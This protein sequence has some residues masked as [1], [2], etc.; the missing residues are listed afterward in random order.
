MSSESDLM[1]S[2]EVADLLGLAH[3]N[4]VSG[5]QRR[6]PDMPMPE[7]D[8]GPGRPKLWRREAVMRWAMRAGKIRLDR[9]P[10]RDPFYTAI[11]DGLDGDL[12]P[13]RFE[14]CV[15]D[16]LQPEIPV[17]PVTG[18]DDLG[19]DGAVFDGE[20]PAFPLIA[21][22]AEDAIGNL[23]KNLTRYRATGGEGQRAVFATSRALTSRK[24]RNLETRAESLG[25][26][27]VQ[28]VDRVGVA[29]RLYRHPR[30]CKELLGITGE[31]PPL[32]RIP[33]SPRPQRTTRLIGREHELRIL[34]DSPDDQVL[35]GPPGSGKSALLSQLVDSAGALFLTA[36]PQSAVAD[37]VR[38]QRPS[39]V[40]VDDAHVNLNM[41]DSLIHLRADLGVPFRIVA[42]SWPQDA[43]LV[44]KR[45]GPTPEK[46]L[47]LDRLTKD[48]IV[49]VV[50]EAG[51][52]GPVDLVRE[53]VNQSEGLPGLAVTLSDICL[54]T[55]TREVV[56]GNAISRDIRSTIEPRLGPRATHLLA[57]LAL[58]GD[59]GM[60]L[61][62]VSAGLDLPIVD[63][64]SAAVD[65]AAA[66][67]LHEVQENRLSVRP[68]A[69]RHALV[70]DIFFSPG[71]RLPVE[72]FVGAASANDF[73][74]TLVQVAGLGGQVPMPLMVEA[75]TEAESPLAWALW[76]RNGSHEAELAARDRP[77][78]VVQYPDPFLYWVPDLAFRIL[79]DRAEGDSRELGPNPDHPLRKL[80][81]WVGDG[82]V[83]TQPESLIRRQNMTAA[84]IEWDVEHPS[85][86]VTGR[87]LALAIHPGFESHTTDP[88]MG[89]TVTMSWGL[90]PPVTLDGIRDMW[91][92][93][94][95]PFVEAISNPTRVLRPLIDEVANWVY[96][97][98]IART[99]PPANVVD[100][101]H[102]TAD[103]MLGDLRRL[104]EGH[105]GLETKIR[106]LAE[107][108]G[109]PVGDFD[110][111]YAI[112]Y[113]D[114]DLQNWERA[115][116]D[117]L[118][119]VHQLADMWVESGPQATVE[120]LASYERMAQEVE[121]RWPRF[122]P[123]LAARLASSIDDPFDWLHLML[124]ENLESDIVSPFM[125]NLLAKDPMEGWTVVAS[126]LN[127][128]RYEW[129]AAVTIL[130]A[131]ECPANLVDDAMARLSPMSRNLFWLAHQ[132]GIQ[133]NALKL[134]LAHP[135]DDVASAVALGLWVGS[136]SAP[137]DPELQ[138][139]WTDAVVRAP[140]Q[141]GD[142]GH[143]LG[144][145]LAADKTLAKEWLRRRLAQRPPPTLIGPTPVID[146]I[147][148]LDVAD[149]RELVTE[150]VVEF[151]SGFI[152]NQ[153]VGDST[154]V[155][156]ALL[157]QVDLKP[158]HLAPLWGRPSGTWASLALLALDYGYSEEEL[159]DAA[160]GGMHSW[161]G[162]ESGMWET[163]IASF[164]ELDTH[165]DT[166]MIDIQK[167]GIEVAT[168]RRDRALTRE[169][170]QQIFGID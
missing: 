130:T 99:E 50:A 112:L 103:R 92:E 167:R 109:L 111:D 162:D 66:G 80:S 22:T 38:A 115:R 105:P 119:E 157:A 160:Y 54:R 35:V 65:L 138:A 73:A 141:R 32:S 137:S 40:I 58:G 124:E 49:E 136:E 84:A 55:G 158:L 120:R 150:L 163:W 57:A 16:I 149:R 8:P 42:S 135:D 151:S 145:V 140:D 131:A 31:P 108:R 71:P 152:A 139:L 166:R 20:G 156:D 52:S 102:A 142:A 78:V 159:A 82:S 83:A 30:W 134:M 95:V 126:I 36:A 144:R 15:V 62:T 170:D 5:Y 169:R 61:Q 48:E 87:V 147:G 107:E 24:R 168:Y 39:I 33:V 77:H 101:M 3:R 25:V 125:T 63:T 45:F 75:L 59:G 23:T 143:W 96:P 37:A 68:Q 164:T 72:A 70:R 90:L 153:L 89:L 121:T 12:D 28:I 60:T 13:R 127:D 67:V 2:Q 56:L 97:S 104:A 161:T 113:G 47:E 44:S 86:E 21:T 7:I 128:P 133:S 43:H 46:I 14:A 69:L 10:V 129:L 51:I 122:S 106:N 91:S 93:R 148:A 88:G 117:R 27:L 17:V 64:R 74:L 9:G 132:G 19:M 100:A 4:S 94:I 98:F 154:E 81:D 116:A 85:S 146:A 6:Y 155:Y 165:S 53:I 1:D 114:L 18:G 11:L 79:F 41:L 123:E 110:V 76:A 29:D 26:Q 34:G 118:V